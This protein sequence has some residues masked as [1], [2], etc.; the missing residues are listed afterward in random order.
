MRFLI[1]GAT[2]LI[3][4]QLVRA[5]LAKNHQVAILSRK[6]HPQLNPIISSTVW[7]LS[8]TPQLIEAVGCADVIINLAG[9]PLAEKRWSVLQKQKIV[10]SRVQATKILV[11]AVIASKNKP[12]TF[13]NASAIGIYG[14]RFDEVI[15][16]D[17][18]AGSGFLAQT[19]MKWEEALRTLTGLG[20]RTVF[21]RTGIVLSTLGGALPKML[22]PFKLGLGGPLGSGKQWLSWIHLQD[23]VGLYIY[24]AENNK[25]QGVLNGTAPHPVNMKQFTKT[26]GQVLHRPAI[27]PVPGIALKIL[28]GEMSSL[29]LEGQKVLP[30]KAIAQGY[31][32]QF[33]TLEGA[34]RDLLSTKA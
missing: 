23:Q 6:V 19:C 14:N 31:A 15:T 1:S 24:A 10:D 7:D 5:L 16:E 4:S 25:V 3:G 22:P 29:L 2:G 13:I 33:P 20:V 9:E 28:L 17:S 18:A 21:M 11:Q 27:A 32:F 12:H 26:L 30:Q 34:F 8:V